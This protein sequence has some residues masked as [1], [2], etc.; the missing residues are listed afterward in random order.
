MRSCGMPLCMKNLVPLSLAKSSKWRPM[1]HGVTCC[2]VLSHRGLHPLLRRQHVHEGFNADH[3]AHGGRGR[4]SAFPLTESLRPPH[5][6]HLPRL[7][8]HTQAGAGW[9]SCQTHSQPRYCITMCLSP[10]SSASIPPPSPKDSLPLF[11]SQL[12]LFWAIIITI[13]SFYFMTLQWLFQDV[14]KD[15]MW[16]FTRIIMTPFLI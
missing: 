9:G 12:S 5:G 8:R 15:C 14:L 11:S 10:Q 4:V 16:L 13:I 7:S 2:H 1:I 6:N 3:H